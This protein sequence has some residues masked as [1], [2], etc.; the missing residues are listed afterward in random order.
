MDS[1]ATHSA[2]IDA[3]IATIKHNLV[4]LTADLAPY[5]NT[6]LVAVTKYS[7]V[8]QMIA[9]YRCGI[10]HFGENK[11]QD[12]QDKQPKLIKAGCTDIHWHFIGHLQRNKVNKTKP[13]QLS[14]PF[15]LIHS[16]D[17]L[18]LAEKL[19]RAHDQCDHQQPILLQ[20]DL[21]DDPNK[22]GFD[23]TTLLKDYKMLS[24]RNHLPNLKIHGL[25]TIGPNPIDRDKSSQCFA[26]LARLKDRL[27]HD[28]G[29]SLS[30]LSMG[31]SQD[32]TWALENGATIIRVGSRLFTAT[33]TT[34]GS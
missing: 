20:V 34:F 5:P 30:Q 27:C 7:T 2:T 21:L 4:G 25:M 13:D 29:D 22:S 26:R 12:V 10:R 17:S 9:A 23:E 28:F 31:M 1:S 33:G 3:H 19:N 32:Y 11:I 16:V 18:A 15:Y 24:N 14:Q 8:E 6:T